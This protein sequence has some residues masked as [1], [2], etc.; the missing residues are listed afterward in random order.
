MRK[1]TLP[2]ALLALAL[3][4][5]CAGP[6]G[7]PPLEGNTGTPDLPWEEATARVSCRI[8]DGAGEG[9]LLLA[10]LDRPL[11]D[12]ENSRHDGKSVY[13]LSLAGEACREKPGPNGETAAETELRPIAV[14][15]DGRPATAADLTDGMPVEVVFTPIPSA[16]PKIRGEVTTTCAGFISRCWTTCGRRTRG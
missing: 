16:P 1:K 12:G 4:G 5:G 10:E 13:R 15:L 6:A 9:E 3:L 11:T 8:V 14:Y 2:A 7:E